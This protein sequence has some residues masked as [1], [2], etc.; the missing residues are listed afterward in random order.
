MVAALK[1]SFV[2]TLRQKGFV[3]SLPHFRRK[4]DDRIDFLDVQFA[5]EGGRF[6]LNIGQ[7]GPKGLEDPAW[8]DLAL[9]ETTVGHV[10][11]SSR[12]H[13]GIL[14]KQ[15][16]DF[17]PRKHDSP[18]AVKPAAYYQAIA[19]SA[20]RAFE[21]DGEKWFSKSRPLRD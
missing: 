21:K 20:A 13:R 12:V 4:L 11:H 6:C 16:F 7:S 5:R 10:H 2:P 8:P 17:G 18:K 1:E 3:G 9:A 19:C 14:F 15:W